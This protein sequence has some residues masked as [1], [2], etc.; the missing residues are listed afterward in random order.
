MKKAIEILQKIQIVTGGIFLAIFLVAV[1]I[2]IFSR[3]LEITV[4]WTE[5]V[6]SYAFIWAV[7]MGASAMVFER[8]HFAFTSLSDRLNSPL[9]KLLLSLVISFIIL[10]FSF[11]MVYYGIKIAIQFWNYHWINIVVLKRGP[12]WLCLPVAGGASVIYCVY[13]MVN[14]IGIYKKGDNT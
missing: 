5:D 4:T 14:D 11:C 10:I 13:H 7:F 12:V 8:R 6:T 1:L 2:Q 9:K 3:Y